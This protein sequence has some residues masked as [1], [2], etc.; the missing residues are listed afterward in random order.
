MIVVEAAGVQPTP[1]EG[2]AAVKAWPG[3]RRW[4]TLPTLFV[5]FVMMSTMVLCFGLSSDRVGWILGLQ[6]VGIYGFVG[7]SIL[8]N[9]KV[10]AA[11]RSTPLGQRPSDWRIDDQGLA[12]SGPDFESRIG[13]RSLVAVVEEKDRMI[14]AASPN[15]NF[16]LPLR[17]LD[18]DQVQAVR[19]I[20][21]DVRARGLLGA[22]VD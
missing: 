16:V 19:T 14:F 1:R 13:W 20:V 3:V 17:V 12:L 8:A 11:G 15:T 2:R 4:T 18:A 7:L 10:M 21:A 6:L 5:G 9:L 22:G